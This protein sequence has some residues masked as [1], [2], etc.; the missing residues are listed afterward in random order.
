MPIRKA[1]TRPLPGR[2]KFTAAL[3]LLPLSAGWASNT[4]AAAV[5]PTK[6]ITLVVPFPP[7]G[8]TDVTARILA[9]ALAAK[10]GQ[11]VVV[12]N[13]AG[14]G[15]NIGSAFVAR[16]R[17]DGYTLVMSGVGT[18]AANV[19]LYDPMPYDPVKDFT[20]ITSLTSSPNVIA[21]NPSV[22]VKTLGE[23]IALIKSKPDKLNYA[24]PGT[25]SSGNLAFELLKQEAQLRVQHIP[26]KGA[27]QAL[28]DVIGG[29]VPIL[30]MVSDTLQPQ[31]EAGKLRILAVTSKQRSTLFPDAPTVAESGFPGFE[32]VSWTGLSAPAHLPI[33]IRDT[34]FQATKAVMTQPEVIAPLLRSGNTID[35]RTPAQFTAFVQAEITKWTGVAARAHLQPQKA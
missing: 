6:P 23:L 33:P 34:V 18:H 2:R 8:T 31:V 35:I 3:T 19:A 24:S 17:P 29:Q 7:G 5:W 12:E 11:S 30:V 9:R 13:R 25:G 14:A 1:C 28:V 21:V 10:L 16:S 20:H 4:L 32:A 26:Y 15:G 27:A 22:P